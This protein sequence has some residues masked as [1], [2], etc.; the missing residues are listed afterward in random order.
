M[1]ERCSIRNVLERRGIARKR[2]S[3]PL[4]ARFAF[5]SELFLRRIAASIGSFVGDEFVF[6]KLEAGSPQV[7][8]DDAEGLLLHLR[9][10]HHPMVVYLPV[11]LVHEIVAV[12]FAR[13][14]Y[15]LLAELSESDLAAVSYFVAR[16]LNDP[17]VFSGQRV[18]LQGISRGGVREVQEQVKF[19]TALRWKKSSFLV[20]AAVGDVLVQRFVAYAAAAKPGV[21]RQRWF[22][23]YQ[24]QAELSTQCVITNLSALLKIRPGARL[25]L[26]RAKRKAFATVN[27]L[28]DRTSS[29]YAVKLSVEIDRDACRLGLTWE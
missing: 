10:F 15:N 18:Y 5:C 19:H 14:H 21:Q 6:G 23:S 12:V 26:D 25:F 8:A 22:S 20:S 4:P 24:L 28:T 7:V 9:L 3:A 29:T 17:N 11:E 16:V 13:G 27:C 1:K 2:E